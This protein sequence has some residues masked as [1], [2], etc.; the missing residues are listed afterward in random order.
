MST[1]IKFDRLFVCSE[2]NKVCYDQK[3]SPH[4]N[5][6]SGRNTSGKSTVL[7]SI[8][9]T[10]GVNDIKEQLKEVLDY[11][12]IFRVNFTTI[13]QNKESKFTI[14][15]EKGSIYIHEYDKNTVTFR[16]IDNNNSTDRSDLKNYISKLLS[17]SMTVEHSGKFQSASIECMFLPFYVS[18]SVGW[19][20]L[21]ESFSNLH[22]YK[23]FKEDYLDYYLSIHNNKELNK[24]ENVLKELDF[25]IH[26]LN[27]FLNTHD[28]H[29]ASQLDESFISQS[30]NYIEEYEGN[31]YQLEKYKREFIDACNDLSLVENHL[32]LIRRTKLN[33]ENQSDNSTNRCPAC[34]QILS[35]SME[36]IYLYY[37]KKQDTIELEK[38]VKEQI[39]KFKTIVK[40]KKNKIN[41]INIKIELNY[42]HLLSK[43]G[44]K[45]LTYK[46]WLENKSTTLLSKKIHNEL[47]ELNNTRDF[48][49][50]EKKKSNKLDIDKLRSPK[51]QKFKK[52]F[53]NFH[54]ELELKDLNED[55]YNN[56]YQINSFP[57][58]GVE[59][60]KTVMAYH[61]ALHSLIH[62]NN[63]IH[64]L[65]FMLDA[66]LKEDIDSNNIMNICKFVGKNLSKSTQSFV[67][68][69]E[70]SDID[71]RKSI[72]VLDVKDVAREYFPENTKVSYI[73]EGKKERGFFS[74]PLDINDNMYQDTLKILST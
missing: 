18:Q 48:Y 5:I 73:A 39:K 66:I 37:S 61:F 52:I 3:F 1:V 64:K 38:K 34:T 62:E 30:Q 6:I 14:I 35:Y 63:S 49:N 50:Q 4:I 24:N 31:L 40:S 36:D 23:N 59:L 12:P 55:R 72:S 57:R 8:L 69:A 43:E 56:P 47:N 15:R 33:T 13:K 27:N 41:D 11:N 25:K 26:N 65:P 45:G 42:N 46:Q 29:I 68:I 44:F 60:H 70:H 71:E 58:Q 16:N 51:I 54:N 22:F 17:F 20:Y 10:F 9:Y 7:H 19:V 21:R 32:K 67:T 2:N 28:F 53:K 74:Q